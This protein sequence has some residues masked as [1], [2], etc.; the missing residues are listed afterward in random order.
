MFI[1]DIQYPFLIIILKW[2]G[3]FEL[4]STESILCVCVSIGSYTDAIKCRLNQRGVDSKMLNKTSSKQNT[5]LH[6]L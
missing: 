2:S 6:S 4:S 3:K 1:T 5:S